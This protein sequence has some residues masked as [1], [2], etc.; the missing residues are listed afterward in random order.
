MIRRKHVRHRFSDAFDG[1]MNPEER[2]RFEQHLQRCSRC[3]AAYAAFSSGLIA[4]QAMPD[5]RMPRPVHIPSGPVPVATGVGT[6]L[7]A[8]FKLPAFG[9][10]SLAGAGAIAAVALV[11]VLAAR[12]AHST[13]TASN[14]LSEGGSGSG[15]VA[16]PGF[17]LPEAAC[18]EMV[19]VVTDATPP[20]GYDLT[21]TAPA[22]PPGVKLVVATQ[23]GSVRSGGT[24]SVYAAI[25]AQSGTTGTHGCLTVTGSPSSLGLAYTS[26]GIF[27]LAIPDNTS[28]G[29]VVHIAVTLQSDSSIGKSSAPH[30]EIDVTVSG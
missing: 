27:T 1:S 20:Q 24:I 29:T 15:A 22:T 28:P 12:G 18:G 25:Q 19:P 7:G 11:I 21:S 14:A 10:A 23:D 9:V 5:E 13:S 4:L 16:A 8:R 17:N 2:R 6:K 26:D 3:A 30:A